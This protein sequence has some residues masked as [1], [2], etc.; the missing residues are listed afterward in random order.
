MNPKM[1]LWLITAM[2]VLF[3]LSAIEILEH[4]AQLKPIQIALMKFPPPTLQKIGR[5]DTVTYW[6][7]GPL[8]KSLPVNAYP[9]G[10]NQRHIYILTM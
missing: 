10:S 9:T 2:T 4:S 8:G 6:S 7:I 1:K 3:L 5:Q